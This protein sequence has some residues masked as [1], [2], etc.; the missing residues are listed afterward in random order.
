[1][2]FPTCFSTSKFKMKKNIIANLSLVS[3]YSP[4]S[5]NI[6]SYTAAFS[7]TFPKA[8][9]HISHSSYLTD[10]VCKTWLFPTL[11]LSEVLMKNSLT[12]QV[13]TIISGITST[14]NSEMRPFCEILYWPSSKF[15]VAG[16]ITRISSSPSMLYYL[17]SIISIISSVEIGNDS[18]LAKR[19]TREEMVWETERQNPGLDWKKE[20]VIKLIEPSQ[21][22]TYNS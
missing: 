5:A 10:R 4:I 11:D 6:Y 9:C 2:F 20:M 19:D 16:L 3:G 22:F 17:R 8:A 21:L 12:C 1:M 7:Q 15:P 14:N 18:Y 13:K